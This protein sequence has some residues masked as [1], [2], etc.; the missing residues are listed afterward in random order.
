M[1]TGVL[2]GSS[3]AIGPFSACSLKTSC[4]LQPFDSVLTIRNVTRLQPGPWTG[5]EHADLANAVGQDG[6]LQ[7]HCA[8][9]RIAYTRGVNLPTSFRAA[10]FTSSAKSLRQQRSLK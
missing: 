4:L 5:V 6:P 7:F 1:P 10:T 2:Y 9:V 8:R 3:A